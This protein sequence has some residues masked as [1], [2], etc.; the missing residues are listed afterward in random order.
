MFGALRQPDELN[1]ISKESKL[2]NPYLKLDQASRREF[3]LRT[4]KAALEAKECVS[5][6]PHRAARNE[7]TK[8]KRQPRNT[9]KGGLN[10]HEFLGV[11]G[12]SWGNIIISLLLLFFRVIRVFRG[13]SSARLGLM[14]LEV[15][16]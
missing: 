10:L 13:S 9:R 5:H 6:P 3:M 11:G 1:T 14:Q 2:M 4:A 16:R 8:G 7:M 12:R 15:E